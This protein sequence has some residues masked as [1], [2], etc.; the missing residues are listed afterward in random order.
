VRLTIHRIV[1]A[2]T[3]TRGRADTGPAGQ[4][5]LAADYGIHLSLR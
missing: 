1:G 4:W 5:R 2:S 3:P